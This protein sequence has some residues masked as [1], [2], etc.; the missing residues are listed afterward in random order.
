[1]SGDHL[2]MKST[3]NEDNDADSVSYLSKCIS[4]KS[5][6]GRRI[7]E[8]I[9]K[10]AEEFDADQFCPSRHKQL[11]IAEDMTE[12]GITYGLQCSV[13]APNFSINAVISGSEYLAVPLFCSVS[14]I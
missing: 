1:M 14:V 2:R 11:A 7:K 5:N 10:S 8:S 13:G 4:F 9:K 12:L 3:D 6:D